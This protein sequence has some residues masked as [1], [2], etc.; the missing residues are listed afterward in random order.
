M[1]SAWGRVPLFLLLASFCMVT[2]A[3]EKKSTRSVKASSQSVK[4]AASNTKAADEKTTRPRGRLPRY[5]SS[6]VDDKQRVE[7]YQIQASYREKMQ[8][9]QA[10]LAKLDLAQMSEI[11]ESLSTEQLKKLDELRQKG[12]AGSGSKSAAKPKSTAKPKSAMKP[13]S[14]A[15]PKSAAKPKSTS[16][17]STVAKRASPR[18]TSKK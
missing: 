7:I 15:K 5:F 12:R 1:F 2:I 18:K 16:T 17:K 4:K 9:L 8:E 6:L 10:E 3:A 14:T 11:E 13:K